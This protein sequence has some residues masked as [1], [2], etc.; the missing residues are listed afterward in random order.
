MGKMARISPGTLG[1][2]RNLATPR[3]A[4]ARLGPRA[5]RW[6]VAPVLHLAISPPA[7][8]CP[9]PVRFSTWPG[10]RATSWHNVAARRRV[11]IPALRPQLRRASLA[12]RPAFRRRA[13]L[14]RPAPASRPD[15]GI[16]SSAALR[17]L[18]V[19]PRPFAPPAGGLARSR[20]RSQSARRRACA[21][22]WA[23][24]ALLPIS[25]HFTHGLRS[26]RQSRPET[27]PADL[28]KC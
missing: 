16:A 20:R 12:Q 4:N 17:C 1:D 26:F 24:E 28:G 22:L 10:A 5:V 18:G 19:T 27:D 9:P 15:P 25:G 11:L 8:S 13:A 14:G 23:N 6:G 21:S 7:A 3:G 2:S